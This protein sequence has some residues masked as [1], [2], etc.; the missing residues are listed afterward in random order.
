MRDES[1]AF[2][3]AT[4]A[5]S[6]LRIPQ[7]LPTLKK[8]GVKLQ[9]TVLGGSHSVATYPPL[10]ALVPMNAQELLPLVRYGKSVN[11]YV[12]IA[13]CET[14]CTFCHYAVET[15]RGLHKDLVRHQRVVRYM[16]ALEKEIEMWGA[17]LRNSGTAISSIYIGGGTPL[18]LELDDLQELFSKI[19]KEFDILPGA[20]IC[21]EGSPLTIMAD[22]GLKKLQW[23]KSTGVTR[24]SFGVQSF[25]DNVLIKAARGYGS[26]VAA[27]ACAR[28]SSVF[29]NWNL[30]LIQSL[31]N[32]KPAEVWENLFYLRKIRP[33]HLTWYHARFADRPQGDWLKDPEERSHFEKDEDTL[34]GRM[35]IWNEL[36]ARGYSLVDGN[37]FVL[38][39]MYVDPFKK[40]RTSVTEDLLGIGAASYSHAEGI[41]FRNTANIG[42]YVEQAE[43][44]FLPVEKGLVLTAAEYLAASYA[45]GL[46][47]VR[48]E[49]ELLHEL[50][51]KE[52]AL[53]LKYQH[54][55]AQLME[56]ELLE[57]VSFNTLSGLRLT[58]RGR[59][60]EDEIL[61]LFWSPSVA[62]RLNKT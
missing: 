35:L 38:S 3:C 4:E 59:L 11:L 1:A 54:L 21:I 22:D 53:A 34:L 45:L 30:D 46:R 37:R 23:L 50:E 8:A 14:R 19:R 51:T 55:C 7:D 6:K 9:R 48:M 20:E 29:Q 16:Q 49:T 33:P 31:Y 61:S 40:T 47:N 42:L 44:G 24:L 27:L 58:Q 43:K 26:G 56:L 28:V 36:E 57:R 10:N 12:H 18:I 52:P 41:F 32:G 13:F 62:E 39:E 15:Y 2:L 5:L 60:F 17:R 25:N